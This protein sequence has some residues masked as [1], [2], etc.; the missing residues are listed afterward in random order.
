MNL[1]NIPLA[2]VDR[3]SADW[4]RYRYT[5]P[6]DAVTGSE[7]IHSVGSKQPVVGRAE[8]ESYASVIGVRRRLACPEWAWQKVPAIV[9]REEPP[10]NLLW[11]SLQETRGGRPLNAMEK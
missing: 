11:L 7:C 10:E 4:D 6:I 3:A 1:E 5:C 9:V 2:R 8:W